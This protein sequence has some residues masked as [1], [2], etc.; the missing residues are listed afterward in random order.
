MR[1]FFKYLDV[2][3]GKEYV[4]GFVIVVMLLFGIAAL[5]GYLK[6]EKDSNKSK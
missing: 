2:K 4:F 3:F 6:E 5:R 1:H